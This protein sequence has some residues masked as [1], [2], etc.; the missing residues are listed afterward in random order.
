MKTNWQ[1][2]YTGTSYHFFIF[3]LFIYIILFFITHRRIENQTLG[4]SVLQKMNIQGMYK[5]VLS[6]PKYK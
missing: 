3:I 1:E 5:Q 4:R 2:E 6:A